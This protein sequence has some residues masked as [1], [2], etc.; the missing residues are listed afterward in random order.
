MPRLTSL[1]LAACL[2]PVLVCCLGA[3]VTRAQ[4]EAY[5]YITSVKHETISNAVQIEVKADGILRWEWASGSAGGKRQLIGVRFT[6]ARLKLDEHFMD[7]DTPP[8]ST[9]M[10]SVPQ[11]AV[12]GTGVVMEVN[13]SERAGFKGA[14]STDERTFVLTVDAPLRAEVAGGKD[15]PAKSKGQEEFLSVET[16]GGLVTIRALRAD[17]HKA[18]AEVARQSGLNLTLDD[19]V[20]HKI[21]VNL[22]AMPPMDVIRAIAAGYGLALSTKGG[23]HMLSE[24]VP[25][26]LTTY[27]RSGTASFP[28][29]YL[30]AEDAKELLPTFLTKYVHFN[31]EQNAVVATAPDQ[32]LAK[33]KR[34]LK[35]VDLPPPLI[36]VDVVAV[37][38]TGTGESERNLSWLY[39]THDKQFGTDSGTGAV[40]YEGTAAGGITGGVIE[41]SARLSTTLRALETSGKANIRSNPRIAAVNGKTA[42]IFIG[43]DRFILVEYQS[44]GVQQERIEAVPVGVRLSVTPWTGGNGEITTSMDVEVSNISE[45]DAATGLP[46]LSSRKASST[47]RTKDGQTIVIGGLRQRQKE[48]T[49]RKIPLL[50]DIPLIGALFRSKSVS[51]VDSE[52]VLFVTPRILSTDGQLADPSQE[53]LRRRLLEP[54]DLGYEAPRPAAAPA[55]AP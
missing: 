12:E 50:G 4:A 26:D 18:I 20:S 28:M 27:N 13:L 23:V 1:P 16:T 35:S 25:R 40:T 31:E 46:L 21:N 6:N 48:V 22:K 55:P 34:D 14:G 30:R 10:L 8:V 49:D 54:E 43:Q 11:D 19:A 38:L 9:I 17:I 32:M 37:E 3:A 5:C 36:M 33:I 47:L 15:A 39:T 44:G 52:L 53:E 41:N 2:T 7:V 42:E 24:G 29:R 45:V 51:N